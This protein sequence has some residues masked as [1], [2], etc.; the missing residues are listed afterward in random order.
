MASGSWPSEGHAGRLGAS[1]SPNARSSPGRKES[2]QHGVR[3]AEKLLRE[4]YPH[5]AWGQTQ[6]RLL[7][8]LCLLATREKANVEAALGT[9]IEM[10]Q[11]EVRWL[12]RQGGRRAELGGE[13]EDASAACFPPTPRRRTA[14]PR[15]WPWRRPTCC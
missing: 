10:A 6:L 11:A 15:C 5:T 7:Q 12:A 13:A 1:G 4:F 2:E 9:F 14:C 3:T 8:G